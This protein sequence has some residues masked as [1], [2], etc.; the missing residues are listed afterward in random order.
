MPTLEQSGLEAAS[1]MRRAFSAFNH[2]VSEFG[3]SSH[4]G[5]SAC[6]EVARRLAHEHLDAYFDA[7]AA[8]HAI[9]RETL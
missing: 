9:G 4:Q 7:I 3:Q 2:E 8:A 5:A 1:T 6:M